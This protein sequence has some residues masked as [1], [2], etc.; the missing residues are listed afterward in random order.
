MTKVIDIWVPDN[1]FPLFDGK[2]L[3]FTECAYQIL[4]NYSGQEPMHYQKITEKAM[5]L[6]M[7]VTKSLDPPNTLHSAVWGEVNRDRERGEIPRFDMEG[8]YV[9]LTQW[10]NIDL[11]SRIYNHNQNIRLALYNQ[12]FQ[13]SFS[14]FECMIT[15][16]LGKM[17]VEHI[18]SSQV[19]SREKVNMRG[20]LVV[21]DVVRLRMAMQVMRRPRGHAVSLQELQKIRSQIRALDNALIV[22]TSQFSDEAKRE[23]YSERKKPIALMDGKQLSCLLMEHEMGVERSDMYLFSLSQGKEKQLSSPKSVQRL[24][25][26]QMRHL[27]AS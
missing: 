22:T 20:T 1:Q 25:K 21:G 27:K 14:Q 23:A 5:D 2:P 10:Y 18:E 12:L 24:K 8:G 7:L 11:Q 17:G 6:G 16:L 15:E 9:G 26:S 13:M 3:T 4:L 19:K